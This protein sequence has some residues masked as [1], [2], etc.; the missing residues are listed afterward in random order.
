MRQTQKL[1][2]V[3]TCDILDVNMVRLTFCWVVRTPLYL[4]SSHSQNPMQFSFLGYSECDP[5]N[6]QWG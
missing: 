6:K 2:S 4:R 5:F 3:C 1:C